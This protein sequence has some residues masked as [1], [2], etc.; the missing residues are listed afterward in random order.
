[1]KFDTDRKGLAWIVWNHHV[2]GVYT[3][4]QIE[5]LARHNLDT[6]LDFKEIDLL[7]N[8]PEVFNDLPDPVQD[9]IYI[10]PNSDGAAIDGAITRFIANYGSPKVT[11]LCKCGSIRYYGLEFTCGLRVFIRISE[12]ILNLMMDVK[13]EYSA[14]IVGANGESIGIQGI[15]DLLYCH[16]YELGAFTFNDFVYTG[17]YFDD[18]LRRNGGHL[19]WVG[20]QFDLPTTFNESVD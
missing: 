4:T 19:S 5:S 20:L 16:L 9:C 15:L 11:Y 17:E 6:I 14:M 18:I 2:L 13:S 3:H 10:L 12:R 1:M 8:S 7:I